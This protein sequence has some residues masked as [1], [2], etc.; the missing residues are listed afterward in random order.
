MKH[1]CKNTRTIKIIKRS[2]TQNVRF[3]GEDYITKILKIIDKILSMKINSSI[4]MKY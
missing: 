3:I 2:F 1:S 4:N